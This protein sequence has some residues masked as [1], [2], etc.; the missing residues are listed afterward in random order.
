MYMIA[1]KIMNNTWS[2]PRLGEWIRQVLLI[3]SVCWEPLLSTVKPKK[4]IKRNTHVSLVNNVTNIHKDY[5]VYISGFYQ[6]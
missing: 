1:T 4:Q 6:L 5:I 2:T 3:L